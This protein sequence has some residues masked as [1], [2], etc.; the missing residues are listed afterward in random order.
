[1]SAATG[2]TIDDV[3]GTAVLDYVHPDDHETAAT[4]LARSLEGD[5]PDDPTLVRASHKDGGWVWVEVVGANLLDDEAVRGYVLCLREV[6]HRQQAELAR[7]EAEEQVR[8]NEERFRGL[9]QNAADAVLVLATDETVL[10]TSPQS[11]VFGVPADDLVGRWA[12]EFVHHDDIEATRATLRAVE[13]TPGATATQTFRVLSGGGEWRWA[14]ARVSNML[15]NEAVG[16][17]VANVADVTDR[18]AAEQDAQRLLRIFEATDDLVCITDTTGAVTHLNRA[19]REFLGV[20]SDAAL[21]SLDLASFFASWELDKLEHELLPALKDNGSWSGELDILDPDGRHIPALVQLLAHSGTSGHS[22]YYSAVMRDISER[23]AFEDRL[24]HQATHDPLT[25]LPNRM[26]LLDRLTMAL[27]RARRHHSVVAVL[28]LDLDHFKVIND[29][30]GHTLG[31]QLLAAIANR[32]ATALRP[33]DTVARFG[34]DEFVVLCEDLNRESQ[35]IMVANRIQRVLGDV[36]AIGATEIFVGASIGISPFDAT[37]DDQRDIEDVTP[38]VLLREADAAMYRAKER[39]RGEIAVFDETLR[40]RSLHRLDTE[41]ALRRALDRDELEVHYQPIIDLATGRVRHL[42]ALVRWQHPDRGM[43]LPAEFVTIAE[44][45]GL[46]VPIGRFV[47]EAACEALAA[48]RVDNPESPDVHVSVNLSGRQLAHPGLVD[49]LK[50]I[51]ATTGVPGEAIVLEMTESLLM[52]DVE[53]SHQTLDRLKSLDV[54]LAVDDFGTGYSSLSYLRS[55]PVDVLKVDRSFVSG[56]GTAAGDEAIVTA[57]VRLAHS[58]GL[59]AVAEGV[60]T[61]AQLARLR[62]LGCNMAQGFYLARPAPA[63]E[64]F[65]SLHRFGS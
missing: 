13:K 48:W 17:I 54:Q 49:D 21:P 12:L 51:I 16:G 60:E 37:S 52:E 30:H 25:G 65:G 56:L 18:I 22:E 29:S 62:A 64:S 40:S 11:R 61:A 45:T 3:R 28:F 24:E 7:R 39:G 19:A 27:A 59:E 53:F 4:N 8:R 2:Y 46:I 10:Y 1:M 44:E 43:L 41:T 14:E 23:K 38:E 5:P 35:A 33:D 57:I 63:E 42:E 9:V 55:F 34:G 58:L 50:A 31:D 32:L 47:L 6:T 20:D 36:F 26:L 15:D